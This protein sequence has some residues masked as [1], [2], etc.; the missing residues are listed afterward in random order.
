M[1]QSRQT[2]QKEVTYSTLMNMMGHPTAEEIYAAVHMSFPHIS[3]ATVYRN[4]AALEEKGAIMRIPKLGSGSDR[5]DKN[6]SP[7][8]HA[9]CKSCG[10]VFDAAL[11]LEGVIERAKVMEDEGFALASYQLI[12]EGTCTK[13]GSKEKKNGTEGIEDGEEPPRSVCG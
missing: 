1:K 6:P 4:L 7:H 5:Y 9:K 13:C 10:K 8:Y 2:L 11:P 12:L 3:K